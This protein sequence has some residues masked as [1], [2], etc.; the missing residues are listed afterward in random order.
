MVQK[1][2]THAILTLENMGGSLNYWLPAFRS[3]NEPDALDMG[4]A[5][6]WL[7]GSGSALVGGKRTQCKEGGAL[8]RKPKE[9]FLEVPKHIGRGNAPSTCGARSGS[10]GVR[11][12]DAWAR[13]QQRILEIKP[14]VG[15][16][17]AGGAVCGPEGPLKA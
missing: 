9:M 15:Q 17:V 10:S 14:L 16:I 12:P 11:E 3:F 2:T 7:P 13:I 8:L 4:K 5:Q 1:R 6:P